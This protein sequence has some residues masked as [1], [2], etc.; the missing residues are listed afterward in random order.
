M[1][2]PSR[3][4]QEFVSWARSSV[5]GLLRE[6]GHGRVDEEQARVDVHEALVLVAVRWGVLRHEEPLAYARRAMHRHRTH[7]GLRTTPP[8]ATSDLDALVDS[9]WRTATTRRRAGRRRGAV[10]AA[11]VVAVLGVGFALGPD[12]AVEPVPAPTTTSEGPGRPVVLGG[13]QVDRLVPAEQLGDLP[14]HPDPGSL[15]LGATLGWTAGADISGLPQSGLSQPVRA[16]ALRRVQG[17]HR[18][19]LVR[20]LTGTPTPYVEVEELLTSQ[21]VGEPLVLTGDMIHPDRDRVAVPQPGRVVLVDVAGGRTRDIP[22]PDERLSSLGWAGNGDIIARGESTWR[23]TGSRVRRAD[24]QVSPAPEELVLRPDGRLERS[25]YAGTGDLVGGETMPGPVGGVHGET[26]SDI[27]G[28]SAAGV[29]LP[30][31]ATAQLDGS[32][33]GVYAVQVDASPRPRVLA[34]ADDSTVMGGLVPLDWG[35]ADQLLL[36][37]R[38]ALGTWVLVWDV[39]TGTTWRVTEVVGQP[40]PGSQPA[41]GEMVG[42]PAL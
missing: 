18:A 16:V 27:A 8:P 3:D 35:P 2:G 4:E 31:W 7:P 29:W 37:S 17:R 30:Q 6:A 32:Y 10:V 13:A 41:V 24:P 20:R 28:W 40:P 23:I 38:S 25:S 34:A 12:A 1:G 11:A 21:V 33:Q 5:A 26:V 15:G 22:V 19:H 36:L 9:A 39:H 42:S 14:R